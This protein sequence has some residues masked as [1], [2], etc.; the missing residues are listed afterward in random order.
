MKKQTVAICLLVAS[1]N[2]GDISMPRYQNPK[3]PKPHVAV[4]KIELLIKGIENEE[5]NRGHMS[6]GGQCKR[7]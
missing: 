2:A 6:F 7:R 1:A 4:F 5:T 3:T